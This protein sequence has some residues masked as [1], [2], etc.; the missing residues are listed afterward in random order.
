MK[1]HRLAK[2]E[3]FITKLSED[4]YTE[5]IIRWKEI[6][7]ERNKELLFPISIKEGTLFLGVENSMVK[8]VVAPILG[9]FIERIRQKIPGSKIKF[10]KLIVAPE[11]FKIKKIKRKVEAEKIIAPPSL[12]QEI[13]LRL[14]S[15]GIPKIEAY[16]MAEI[17]ALIKIRQKS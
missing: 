16:K 1:R 8:S 7:G 14:I 15:E 4:P 17:E 2:I 3:N 5:L 6:V 11:F 12:I 13:A 9:S 10:I